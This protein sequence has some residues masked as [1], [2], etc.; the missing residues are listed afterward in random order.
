MPDWDFPV[1]HPPQEKSAA[2]GEL[3]Q[4]IKLSTDLSPPCMLLVLD[5]SSGHLTPTFM[6]HHA[7]KT[8]QLTE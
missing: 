3:S 6:L 2:W 5:I 4:P 1:S 8:Q 7:S